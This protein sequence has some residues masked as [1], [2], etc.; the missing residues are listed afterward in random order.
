LLFGWKRSRF[1]GIALI[2]S[3]HQGLAR[4][5]NLQNIQ[6]EWTSRKQI[7]ERQRPTL[8]WQWWLFRIL[9][10]KRRGIVA[11]RDTRWW[12]QM[13]LDQRLTLLRFSSLTTKTSKS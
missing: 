1:I 4:W 13:T 12:Q 7:D 3:V 10:A 11:P 6:I 2:Q 5:L 8:E 9:R